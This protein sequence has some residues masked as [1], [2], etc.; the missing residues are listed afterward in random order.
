[1]EADGAGPSLPTPAQPIQP[2]HP[3]LP[4]PSATRLRRRTSIL[5]KVSRSRSRVQVP[6]ACSLSWIANATDS[7]L[8][9]GSLRREFGWRSRLFFHQGASSAMRM[10]LNQ[11][12]A[13]AAGCCFIISSIPFFI[14]F[15]EGSAL[16][17]PT[18][19]V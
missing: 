12:A 3:F 13:V 4:G 17:V 10:T 6:G 18:I 19:Q 2:I 1:M 8:G 7:S 16:W 14:S 11:S 9:S 5:L 15:A